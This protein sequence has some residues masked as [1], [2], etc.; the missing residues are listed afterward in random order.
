MEGSYK[1]F[2]EL[3]LR[4]S[5]YKEL[6]YCKKLVNYMLLCDKSRFRRALEDMNKFV[7]MCFILLWLSDK[8]ANL[9][10]VGSI[11]IESSLFLQTDSDFSYFRYYS[12]FSLLILLLLRLS[13]SSLMRWPKFYIFSILLLEKL[14]IC[15][16][17]LFSRPPIC[18]IQLFST[19][20]S[21]RSGQH[22]KFYMR[23][24]RL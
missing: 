7:G 23:S 21:L 18:L 22:C 9:E 2:T 3:W 16:P 4:F 11:S 5:I 14:S 19:W 1:Y 20:S 17:L 8:D 10:K 15:K 12:P 6:R 24:M 13:V